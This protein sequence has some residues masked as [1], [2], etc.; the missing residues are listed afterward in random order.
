MAME[1]G[2]EATSENESGVDL[3]RESDGS[4]GLELGDDA[5][6]V[7][8]SRGTA[9][10]MLVT[11][12]ADVE[13]GPEFGSD[14]AGAS[15]DA[16]AAKV[17]DGKRRQ[18]GRSGGRIKKPRTAGMD[19]A[20]AVEVSRICPV[21]VHVSGGRCPR[22]ASARCTTRRAETRTVARSMAEQFEWAHAAMSELAVRFGETAYRRLARRSWRIST[23]FSGLGTVE[24]A[25]A[26][27]KAASTAALRSSLIAEVT[28]SCEQSPALRI[29][30][31]HRSD[32]CIFANVFGRIENGEGHISSLKG[33]DNALVADTC[34]CEKHATEC[35]IQAATMEVSGSSCRPWSRM[36]RSRHRRG[37][38]HPDYQAFK[39][40][41]RLMRRDSPP[42]IIHE[43]V[44]GFPVTIMQDELG[45]LYEV[46]R[47]HVTPDDVGFGFINRPRVYDVLFLRGVVSG[48]NLQEV[49]EVLAQRLRKDVSSWPD[50]VWKATADELTAALSSR[51]R[52]E[53]SRS[54]DDW[55]THLTL[56][57][58]S[59]IARYTAL[60]TK[61]H[62]SAP[63]EAA[64]CLFDLSVT[65]EFHGVSVGGVLPTMRHRAAVWW[66]PSRS[67]WMLPREKAACM[68]FPVYDD[69][70]RAARVPLDTETIGHIAGNASPIGN[71]MHVANVGV[72]M[73]AAMFAAE[74]Q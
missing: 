46:T 33:I 34:A 28:S 32:G 1:L 73:L 41:V 29:L 67:R 63:A 43:N 35:R 19:R 38:A 49:Y 16:V 48:V 13:L 59:Y 74:W 72:V 47:L 53:E 69:L 3:G 2:L 45:E 15:S 27:L 36:N 7:G 4:T 39:A 50:W 57:Q 31:S 17:S 66:S 58:Q 61:A 6:A 10:R 42:I 9:S 18:G 26:M 25:L 65:P 68:G 70:A 71:A 14:V 40:W 37:V 52:P 21:T 51:R 60:W 12:S 30:L 56:E 20:L 11:G 22:G 8:T 44:I 54:L 24:V 62:G 23:H 5:V 55:S 64:H